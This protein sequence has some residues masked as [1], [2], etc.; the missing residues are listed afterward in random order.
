M[1][2]RALWPEY[3]DAYRIALEKCSTPDAPWYAIPADH[4]WYRNYAVTRLLIEALE[5][6][7]PQYPAG[8][9]DVEVERE[10][11]LAS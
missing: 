2:E 1:D 3:Q 10:R 4:K 5:R 9:F 8:K 6:I 7:D 11:V